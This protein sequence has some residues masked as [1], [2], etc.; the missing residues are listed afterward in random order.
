MAAFV[1]VYT[2]MSMYICMHVCIMCIAS[3]E[4]DLYMRCRDGKGR[5]ILCECRGAQRAVCAKSR[6]AGGRWSNLCANDLSHR[7][8]RMTMLSAAQFTRAKYTHHYLAII[9]VVLCGVCGGSDE[10][11][12]LC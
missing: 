8:T 5:R 1:Y 11:R 12:G 4:L 7:Y 6:P 9:C 10:N 2:R 3:T